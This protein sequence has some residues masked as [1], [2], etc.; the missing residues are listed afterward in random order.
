MLLALLEHKPLKRWNTKGAKRMGAGGRRALTG[1]GLKMG[2]YSVVGATA[3]AATGLAD[4]LEYICK[5]RPLS[6]QINSLMLHATSTDAMHALHY[7]SFLH[8]LNITYP[9]EDD[10]LYTGGWLSS[11]N[12]TPSCQRLDPHAAFFLSAAYVIRQTRQPW[13]WL[14]ILLLLPSRILRQP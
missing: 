10:A 13:K 2:V 5:H 11:Q 6:D 14:R 3:G 4:G 12:D 7:I 8:H 1:G 9:L